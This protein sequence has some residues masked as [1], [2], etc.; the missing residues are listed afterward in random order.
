MY[1]KKILHNHSSFTRIMKGIPTAA[2][3]YKYKAGELRA[4]NIFCLSP[5]NEKS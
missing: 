5:Y 2:F 3:N 1:V 4:K